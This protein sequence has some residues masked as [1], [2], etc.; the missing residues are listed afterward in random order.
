[1]AFSAIIKVEQATSKVEQ[2]SETATT[3]LR[4]RR[5]EIAPAK[6]VVA[7]DKP[8][9]A[10][11]Q[12]KQKHG[13]RFVPAKALGTDLH[14]W[15]HAIQQAERTDTTGK[16]RQ[17][18]VS[19]GRRSLKDRLALGESAAGAGENRGHADGWAAC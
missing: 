3:G 17:V 7:A 13:G 9:N 19:E 12:R 10:G 2:I 11:A 18:R 14:Q 16:Q 15:L 8:V 6:S 4:P 1:M 5:S